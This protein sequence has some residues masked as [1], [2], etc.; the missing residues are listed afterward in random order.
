MANSCYQ[1]GCR[2]QRC[3]VKHQ[4]L[5][6]LFLL[7]L[8]NGWQIDYN[9]NQLNVGTYMYIY[10][11]HGSYISW[12]IHTFPDTITASMQKIGQLRPQNGHIRDSCSKQN[13][14]LLLLVAPLAPLC[15]KTF[16][17]WILERFH[18]FFYPINMSFWTKNPPLKAF[19]QS[20]PLDAVKSSK[21][22]SYLKWDLFFFRCNGLGGRKIYSWFKNNHLSG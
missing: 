13:Q 10:I 7:N 18:V 12:G 2:W 20:G 22:K 3:F 11:I 21:L 17:S 8:L 6:D 16:F 15:K 4:L 14:L 19:L 1:P 9:K 5:K